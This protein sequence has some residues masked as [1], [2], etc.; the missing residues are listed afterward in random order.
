MLRQSR[1][2]VVGVVLAL[3]VFAGSA[4][5]ECAW[6]L[7]SENLALGKGGGEHW[8]IHRASTDLR[9][10]REDLAQALSRWTYTAANPAEGVKIEV[11]R[12]TDSVTVNA[13]DGQTV[14]QYRCLPETMDPRGPK[15]GGR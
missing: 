10:C 12:E 11:S 15:G 1:R 5:A 9:S 2:V 13:K 7:W 8:Q 3:V 4:A 14:F 6:V